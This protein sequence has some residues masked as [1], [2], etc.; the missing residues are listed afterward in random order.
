MAKTVLP[1]KFAEW[2][3]LDRISATVHAMN[4][5]FREISKDDYGLDGEIEVVVPKASGQGFETTGGIIKVQAK[6]G[7]SYVTQDTSTSFVTPVAKDDLEGWRKSTFP[8]AFIVYH[9]RDDALYWK[10]VKSYVEATQGVFK[11]PV[12]LKFDKAADRFTPEAV[13]ALRSWADV[14]QPRISFQER[15]RHYSNLFPVR[16]MPRLITCAA[17][18]HRTV[19]EVRE[20]VTG[21]VAPFKVVGDTLYTLADL[22]DS[23][24][25]LRQACDT[26]RVRDVNVEEWIKDPDRRRDFVTM[27]NLLL[28]SHLWRVGLRYVGGS[29]KRNYFPRQDEEGT[30]FKRPWFN[31]RTNRKSRGRIIAKHYRYGLDEFWRHTAANISFRQFGP[32]WY[33]QVIPKYFFTVDGELPYDNEKVGPYTTRIRARERNYHVLN[34]VLFWADVLSDGKESVRLRLDGRVLVDIAR[35]PMTGIAPFAIPFDPASFE[36]PEEV[37]ELE[38]IGLFDGLLGGTQT[39]DDDEDE[40]VDESDEY[41][42]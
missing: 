4:C 13:T 8:V 31:I 6:S 17:T 23:H 27:L 24:V 35:E 29:F 28:G 7:T 32:R 38:Q 41:L 37:D 15:E 40:D 12:H 30:D 22:R 1:S 2:Q 26:T 5:I 9:P 36:E 16:R 21:Y 20:A 25:A 34:Q 18:P 11:P 39:G 33:L 10:E 14:E 42:D 3:G 19:T